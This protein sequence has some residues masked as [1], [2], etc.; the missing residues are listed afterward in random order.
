MSDTRSYMAIIGAAGALVAG[1][2]FAFL[3]LGSSF[4]STT[5]ATQEARRVKEVGNTMI[6]AHVAPAVEKHRKRGPI[7][8]ASSGNSKRKSGGRDGT[9]RVV[10][11]RVAVGTIRVPI[12]NGAATQ[13]TGPTPTIQTDHSATAPP[14]GSDDRELASSR[15]GVGDQGGS[16]DGNADG[17]QSGSAPQGQGAPGKVPVE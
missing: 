8:V 1:A 17:G 6:L 16:A 4:D 7:H 13:A 14:D 12:E 2:I 15:G 9:S 5:S 3:A 10:T 11:E